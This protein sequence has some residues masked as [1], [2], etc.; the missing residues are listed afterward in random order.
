MSPLR[1]LRL[2]ALSLRALLAHRTRSALA[3]LGV[4]VGVAAVVLV[5]AL[6]EG[7]QRELVAGMASQGAHLLVVRPAQTR[8]LV[9]RREVAGRV[10]T[11]TP[12][13]GEALAELAP[14]AELAPAVDGRRK[15]RAEAG[16]TPALVV[17]TTAAFL[18]VRGFEVARGAFF[19][20]DDDAGAAR[21]VVLGARVGATLFPGADPLGETVRIGAAP[22]E[23]VGVLA[24][25]GVT[26]DGAEVDTQVYVPLR[27]ALRRVYNARALTAV[28]VRVREGAS[29]PRAEAE[30]G[31]L[32]RE[33]HRLEERGRPDDFEV[34]DPARVLAVKR[35]VARA[36]ALFTAGLAAVSLLVGGT[37]ILA[38][39]LLSVRE[40]TPEIGVRRAVGAR[41]RD[42]LVQFLGEAVALSAAGGLAGVAAGALGAAAVAG[43]TG[44]PVRV[45]A[46]A[47]AAGLA[48]SALVGLVFGVLPALR[49]ARL[50]PSVAI[51][52]A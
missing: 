50:P 31:A 26:A 23:V 51:S 22:F 37:G 48:V 13:D 2:L 42:V 1:T 4:A 38:L 49:A 44:W 30:I 9:A 21:V 12:A 47:A 34:Q 25:Q 20:E 46:W 14:V 18:R 43:A 32:L 15:L 16:A 19:G 28:Y 29:F 39:M 33:R 8:R 45:P 27:T 52:R 36:V 6:G 10:A 3:A 40:R 11:L 35:Q 24:P 7:A 41:P 5:T 17:G